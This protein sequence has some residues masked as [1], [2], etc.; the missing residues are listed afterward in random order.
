MTWFQYLGGA[1]LGQLSSLLPS[2]AGAREVSW[3]E[4]AN[5]PRHVNARVKT[6]D[7]CLPRG[8]DPGRVRREP[9]AAVA[10]ALACAAVL[11]CLARRGARRRMRTRPRS[12]AAEPEPL[13]APAAAA[14]RV[15]PVR[16]RV[17][18]R[19]RRPSGP[20]CA[21]PNAAVHPRLRRR[22]RHPRRLAAHGRLLHRRRLRVLEARPE[23]ALSPRDPPAGARRGAP[24][25]PDGQ[26]RR[27]VRALSARALAG[28]GNEWDV[29][30][31]GPSGTI[32]GGLEVELSAARCSTCPWRTARS[33]CARSP[34]R[35]RRSTTRASRTSSPSRSRSRRKTRSERPSRVLR[36]GAPVD[37]AAALP[38]GRAAG[39]R[40]WRGP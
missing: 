21:D 19:G 6:G 20:V 14:A 25:L 24:L 8:R 28:Y 27:T 26:E 13:G 17:H 34:T 3:G 15:H 9:G 37:A 30:T 33:T 10:S 18:R 38:A 5:Q 4:Y 40:I 31:W 1:D 22:H 11:A 2:P 7:V 12:A 23:Q 32:G 16:R 39:S 36:A 35:S 29:A